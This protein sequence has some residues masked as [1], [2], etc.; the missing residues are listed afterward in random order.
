MQNNELDLRRH[1]DLFRPFNFSENIHVI[2]AGATGSW[3]ALQLAKLGI[4]GVQINLYDFDTVEEHNIPNQNFSNRHVGKGKVKATA[5]TIRNDTGAI[6]RVHGKYEDQPLDGYVFL[7]V[8][9]MA[10]RE[11]IYRR[12][13]TNPRIKLIIEPRLGLN[14]GYMY[15]FVPTYH[16][17]QQRYETTLYT[18]DEAEVSACGASQSAITSA[19]LLSSMCTRALI[20]HHNEVEHMPFEIMTDFIY[21]NQIVTT[22]GEIE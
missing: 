17:H 1:Q 2:G 20:N 16:S 8:D 10:E 22:W 3:V 12:C 21:Y 4:D 11:R 15:S 18:D 5:R 7:L 19:M 6:V 9:S 13:K 14:A